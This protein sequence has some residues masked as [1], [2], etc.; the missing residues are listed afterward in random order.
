[1]TDDLK[2]LLR[3]RAEDDRKIQANNEAVAAALKGQRIL[4]EE[5]IRSE[6]NTFAMR[7]CL[8]YERCARNDAALAK[9]WD[10]AADRIEALELS[11]TQS[12][13]DLH[14]A[15]KAQLAKAVE[16]LRNIVDRPSKMVWGEDNE[17]AEAMRDMEKIAEAALAEIEKGEP[18]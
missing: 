13:A 3:K 1:M 18:K 17:K 12:R 7:L 6:P 2:A 8:D 10:E 11:L 16:A 14:D 5:G 4:F 15:T 9:D